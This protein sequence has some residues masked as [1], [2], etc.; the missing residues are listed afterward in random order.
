[1]NTSLTLT[2]MET[3]LAKTAKYCPAWTEYN[4]KGAEK[5]TRQLE[6]LASPLYNKYHTKLK[7]SIHNFKGSVL[8]LC[9]TGLALQYMAQELGEFMARVEY[10]QKECLPKVKHNQELYQWYK[11]LCEFKVKYLE[12]LFVQ[13]FKDWKNKH[14]FDYELKDV[15]IELRN[16][17]DIYYDGLINRRIK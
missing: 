7:D 14:G 2:T 12:E 11:S 16:Q 6:E 9:H 10:L 13:D 3:Y 1:M 5:K 8:L 15:M 17:K 4:G